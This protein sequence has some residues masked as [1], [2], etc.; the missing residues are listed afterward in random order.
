MVSGCSIAWSPQSNYHMAVGPH[1]GKRPCR[2]WFMI[3]RI[4]HSQP[5]CKAFKKN[6]MLRLFTGISYRLRSFS[7]YVLSSWLT[8]GCYCEFADPWTRDGSVSSWIQ[9][10]TLAW[11]PMYLV[12]T[13]L[14]LLRFDCEVIPLH[15]FRPMCSRNTP[16]C[17][18]ALH[19]KRRWLNVIRAVL[20]MTNTCW[21]VSKN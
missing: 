14:L 16:K 5:T 3:T 4:E 10:P 19:L 18:L 7:I 12:L 17:M 11:S 9:S 1:I 15:N 6:I 13:S 20:S 21:G 2:F 8:F